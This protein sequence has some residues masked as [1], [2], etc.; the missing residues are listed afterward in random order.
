MSDK[1]GVWIDHRKAVIVVA[2]AEG[3]VAT[4]LASEVEAHPHFGGQQDGG[5]EKK[6]E[7]RRRHDLDRYYDEVIGRVK[8]PGGLLVLGPGEAKREFVK[9]F[10]QVRPEVRC[11]VDIETTG[12]LTD[13]QIVEKVR[14]HFSIAR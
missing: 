9:R 1:V 6:Y 4:T 12:A 3:L 13:P 5:G 11:T 7:E 10:G 8:A 2:S 14:E